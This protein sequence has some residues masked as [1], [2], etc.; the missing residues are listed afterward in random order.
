MRDRV[1]GDAREPL[2]GGLQVAGRAPDDDRQ[3]HLPVGLGGPARHEHRVVRPDHRVRR[4]EEHHRLGGRFGSGLAGVVVVVQPDAH[5]LADACHRRSDAQPRGVQGGQRTGL[6]GGPYPA[7][8][9]L[10]GEQ[11][12]VDVRHDARQV[13]QGPVGVEQRGPLRPRRTDSQ[14]LHDPQLLARGQPAR[15][16]ATW[17]RQQRD[18]IGGLVDPPRPRSTPQYPVHVLDRSRAPRA[19]GRSVLSA[20]APPVRRRSTSCW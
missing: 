1:P 19:S 13:S 7:Q 4:L 15:R 17:V 16:C 18:S 2:L 5:D 12:A 10:V 9:A 6:G 20:G 11:F 8:R 14:Q 3:L